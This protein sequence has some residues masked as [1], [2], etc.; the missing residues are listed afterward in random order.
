MQGEFTIT[1][2]EVLVSVAIFFL[3]LAIGFLISQGISSSIAEKNEVYRKALKIE[4]MDMYNYAKTT[5]VGNS[6]TIY[7][8]DAEVPQSVPELTG[9]YL[10]IERIYE[11]EHE[12]ERTVEET[13]T[14]SNGKKKTR[15]KK[16]KYWEWDLMDTDTY[17]SPTVNFNGESIE[18]SRI[19][20]LGSYS[21]S[22]DENTVTHEY[23]DRLGWSSTYLKVGSHKRWSFD[24]I[25]LHSEGSTYVD[26][27]DGTVRSDKIPLRPNTSVPDL[28]ESYLSSSGAALVIFWIFWIILTGGAIFAY[29]YLDNNY[30]EDDNGKSLRRRW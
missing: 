27:G 8:L 26:L 30:L 17:V 3:M 6:F 28:Y 1:K 9:E 12:K 15:T 23:Q 19:R 22:L 13:Y 16:V 14:D 2:R 20:G 11:E 25:P 4:D 18:W 10:Y 29:C 7:T 5:G 24:V 21:E